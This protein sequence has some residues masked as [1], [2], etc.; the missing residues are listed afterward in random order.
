MDHW[1]ERQDREIEI[2]RPNIESEIESLGQP[3]SFVIYFWMEY[4]L[5]F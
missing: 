1:T 5:S 3:I 2:D 4:K